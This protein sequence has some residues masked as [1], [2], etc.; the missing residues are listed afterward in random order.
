MFEDDA[1]TKTWCLSDSGAGA[2]LHASAYQ[3][4]KPEK[5]SP[6][7]GAEN[8]SAEATFSPAA[9]TITGPRILI[10]R[11]TNALLKFS[12][13]EVRRQGELENST[14]FLGIELTITTND[15]FHE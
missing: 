7:A 2:K 15:I 12:N 6:V 11:F 3:A 4:V 10:P 9:L 14:G 5:V 1:A 8:H 13:C